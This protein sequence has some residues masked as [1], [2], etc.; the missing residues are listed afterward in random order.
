[1]KKGQTKENPKTTKELVTK[2]TPSRAAPNAISKDK[3]AQEPVKRSERISKTQQ[4]RDA[5]LKAQKE[6]NTHQKK[7]AL[8]SK[9]QENKAKHNEAKSNN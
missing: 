1:M 4:K 5:K 9:A 7:A 3:A 6:Q 2:N 8:G